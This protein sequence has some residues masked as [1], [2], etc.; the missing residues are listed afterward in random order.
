MEDYRTLQ[1]VFVRFAEVTGLATPCVA[2]LTRA[3]GMGRAASG[4]AKAARIPAVAVVALAALWL[5]PAG[6]CAAM[7]EEWEGPKLKPV[8]REEVF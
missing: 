4:T 5:P 1:V 7:A 8:A 2:S 3:L 6:G